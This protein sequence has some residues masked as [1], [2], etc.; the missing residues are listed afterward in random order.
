[1]ILEYN[2]KAINTDFVCE[3][4]K[5]GPELTKTFSIYFGL[6]NGKADTFDFPTADE[7]DMAYRIICEQL[8]AYKLFNKEVKQ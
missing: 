7:R 3:F 4:F 1:M 6:N 5:P 8:K 2:N